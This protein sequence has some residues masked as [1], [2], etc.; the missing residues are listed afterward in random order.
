MGEDKRGSIVGETCDGRAQEG[1]VLSARIDQ[2]GIDV[3]V[4][5][6]FVT[7]P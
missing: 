5:S 3:R 6:I 2:R 4:G 1:G 7:K